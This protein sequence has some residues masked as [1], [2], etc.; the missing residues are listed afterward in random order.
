MDRQTSDT[1]DAVDTR[2][3]TTEPYLT[4]AQRGW[5]VYDR[6][7]VRLGEVAE[8]DDES[9]VILLDARAG[10]KARVPLRLVAEGSPDEERVTLSIGGSELERIT[11]PN[12]P[13]AREGT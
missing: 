6:A 3:R 1:S 13:E 8:R 9:I 11:L 10:T 12:Q 2:E 5:H 4:W 7:G